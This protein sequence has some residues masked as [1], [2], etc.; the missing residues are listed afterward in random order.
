[1][2]QRN[3]R[4]EFRLTE[5]EKAE[6]AAAAAQAKAEKAAAKAAER[7]RKKAARAKQK[8]TDDEQA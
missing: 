8:S 4:Y 7:E 5:D 6:K 1:M 2:A 3:L